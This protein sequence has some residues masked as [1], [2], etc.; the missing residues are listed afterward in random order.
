MKA[1][2]LGI[3]RIDFTN[4]EGETIRGTNIYCAFPDEKVEGF[5]AEKF[6]LKEGF[7]LPKDVKIDGQINLFFNMNGKVEAIT[8]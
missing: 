3:Q 4:K 6:F 1:T 8:V 5:R 2:L 7:A